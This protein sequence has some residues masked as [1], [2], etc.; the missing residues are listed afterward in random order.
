[1]RAIPRISDKDF[2]A[3]LYAVNVSQRPRGWSAPWLLK[4]HGSFS[5]DYPLK[6]GQPFPVRLES[7]DGLDEVPGFR[8]FKNTGTE[9]PIFLPFWDKRIE[10]EPWVKI[11]RNAYLR[12]K[13]ARSIIVWGYSL[14]PTDL[15]ALQFFRLAGLSDINLCVIDISTQTQDRWRRL[16]P[17]SKFWSYTSIEEFFQSPPNWWDRPA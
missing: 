10:R 16:L 3:W 1:M 11:W 5:W 6:E 7:W 4:L 2:G 13:A 12:L 15:K 14:P 17:E 9:Y 8:R